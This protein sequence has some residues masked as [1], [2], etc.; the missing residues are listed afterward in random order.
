[1]STSQHEGSF[2]VTTTSGRIRGRG[3]TTSALRLDRWAA[4]GTAPYR[5]SVPSPSPR[6]VL[7]SATSRRYLVS[8]WPWRALAYALTTPLVA[9]SAAVPLGLVT[10]PWLVLGARV[11]VGDPPS[12]PGALALF[13][14][15]AVLAAALGPLVA[16]PLATVERGRLRL[17]TDDVPAGPRRL[18]GATPGAWLRARYAEPGAWRE[19]VYAALLVTLIPALYV[20]TAVL[21]TGA[22]VMTVSPALAASGSRV[23]LG[24]VTLTT[25]AEAVPYALLGV[26]LLATT[27]YQLA[28]L[29]GAHAMLARA[30]LCGPEPEVLR[31]RLVEVT[32]SRARLVDAFEAERIRIERDLHDGAQARVVSLAMKLGTTRM[33]L[34]AGSPAAQAVAE[35]HE[36]AKDLMG[37]LRRLVRGIH[38]RVLADR[39]LGPA[40]EE[41]ADDAAV[42]VELTTDL[43]GDVP[44]QVEAAAYYAAAEALTNVAK[45]ARATTVTLAAHVRDGLL[46]VEATDDGEGGA[47][48]A[49]GTGLAGLADRV[50]AAGGRML[51][52]S[53]AGGPTVV[54][55]EIPCSPSE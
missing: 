37:E 39:G 42:P 2:R 22:A 5:E 6:S 10:M 36:Q 30:L 19:V 21:T 54:R 32:R 52:S 26:V 34:P 20:P 35:A 29:T 15:G 11:A 3:S 38:P 24:P 49:R 40:L 41:L 1:M 18:A 13:V 45:H 33:D 28:V 14:S 46:V 17:L 12:W 31:A 27:P 53:P 47:D 7:Q 43:P 50:A 8:A 48:P 25:S 44:A 23:A 9:V 55:V 16:S 4:P 51:L